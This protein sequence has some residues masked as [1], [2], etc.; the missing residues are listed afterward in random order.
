M[1]GAV[2]EVKTTKRE[3]GGQGHVQFDEGKSV[4]PFLAGA[5][6]TQ[7]RETLSSRGTARADSPAHSCAPR[8]PA[9][10]LAASLLSLR[11]SDLGHQSQ[12]AR[13]QQAGSRQPDEEWRNFSAQIFEGFT[14]ILPLSQ[15]LSHSFLLLLLLPPFHYT[16]DE[17]SISAEGDYY[18]DVRARRGRERGVSE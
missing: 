18:S 10:H 4:L 7:S 3:E 15:R 1:S 2:N 9:R 13:G 11:C 8:S 16:V 6:G 5:D 17:D 12:A 14:F